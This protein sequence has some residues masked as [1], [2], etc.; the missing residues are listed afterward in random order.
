MIRPESP[1]DHEAIRLIH[2]RAFENKLEAELVDR[3]RAN[4][5]LGASL[6][7]VSEES[8]VGHIAFSPVT[9]AGA[10]DGWGMAPLA[11]LPEH[12]RQ[13]FGS[14]L[15]EAGI[16]LARERGVA[17]MVVLGDPAY[18]PRFGFIP[19]SEF[20]L[21]NEYGVDEPFM[22]LPLEEGALDAHQGLVRYGAEFAIF[23]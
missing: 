4:G 2:E 14:A 20:G 3:L 9:L 13:G 8:V 23:A 5:N 16:S 19:A 21:Q 10:P 6:V 15:I 7:A 1:E 18:Y 17:W 12:Q 22:A 11:V